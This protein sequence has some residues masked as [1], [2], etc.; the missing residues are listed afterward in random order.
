MKKIRIELPID[1]YRNASN[2]IMERCLELPEWRKAKNVHVYVS[3]INNEVD[4]LGL[5]YRLFDEGRTVVVPKCDCEG[6]KLVG[7][8]IRSFD[9]LSPAKFGLIEPRYDCDN[10]VP[11]EKLDLVLAPLV[12]FDRTGGRLGLGGG[13]YDSLL[14]ECSCPVV[15]LA[16]SFQEV[17]KV[18]TEPHDRKLS[19]IITEKEVIRVAHE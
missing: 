2:A 7:I 6:K 5:I 18:P 19:V 4:T 14:A 10:V 17:D 1:Q 9:E 13:Y 3:V 15:G 12:A 8:C 11:P 16:Y